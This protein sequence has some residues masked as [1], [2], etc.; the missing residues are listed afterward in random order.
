MGTGIGQLIKSVRT[1]K[2]VA[3][4]S[5]SSGICAA[6]ALARYEAGTREMDGLT[7]IALMHRLGFSADGFEFMVDTEEYSYYRWRY[8]THTYIKCGDWIGLEEHRHYER[9]VPGTVNGI[10][11]SQYEF[12]IEAVI[13]LVRGKKDRFCQCID[14]ALGCTVANSANSRAYIGMGR[15]ELHLYMLYLYGKKEK[16]LINAKEIK[17]ILTGIYNYVQDRVRDGCE[18]QKICTELVMAEAVLVGRS[19]DVETESVR[20]AHE[21][22][23]IV[24]R[25]LPNM[26]IE[27]WIRNWINDRYHICLIN[28]YLRAE[29]TDK[30]LNQIQFVH[31]ICEAE[32]Y[33]RVESG[34]RRMSTG[35]YSRLKERLGICYGNYRYYIINHDSRAYILMKKLEYEMKANN[36]NEANKLLEM[37]SASIDISKSENIQYIRLVSAIIRRKQGEIAADCMIEECK[38]ILNITVDNISRVRRFLTR[39]E[40]ELLYQMAESYHELGRHNKVETII[41]IVVHNRQKKSSIYDEYARRTMIDNIVSDEKKSRDEN[42][43]EYIE[44]GMKFIRAEID[45]F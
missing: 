14:R 27:Q 21:N 15:F 45:V 20:Y 34:S 44:K 9:K 31:G 12:Y 10:L 38:D 17:K 40:L 28:E 41:N 19:E 13:H 26:S 37:I 25:E 39:T 1:Y 16:K 11:H 6:S 30:G 36:Y 24:D 5:L 43:E 18:F 2:N 22:D 33:S 8:R 42:I 3:Q 29:R 7:F 23:S 32:T 35:N 4:N